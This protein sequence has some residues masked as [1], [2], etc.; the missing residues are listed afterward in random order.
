MWI[1]TS[2]YPR[3]SNDAFNAVERALGQQIPPAYKEFLRLENGGR[4]TPN[5]DAS[6][7]VGVVEFFGTSDQQKANLLE[8]ALFWSGRLSKEYLPIAD[9][10]GG[11]LLLLRI[12][13]DTA[14]GA[15]IAWDHEL[16]GQAEAFMKREKDF[17]AF[18]LGVSPQKRLP[19]ANL[20]RQEKSLGPSG[21][22]RR[23]RELVEE[24]RSGKI[25]VTD[26]VICCERYI[27]IVRRGNNNRAD[28]LTQLLVAI[29]LDNGASETLDTFRTTLTDN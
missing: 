4:A 28:R 23:M 27:P 15:V 26:F 12:G 10:E 1:L 13:S 21:A 11:N 18:L 19:S 3:A 2:P 20:E 14:K 24:L 16:E 29:T 8:K 5:V 9:C 6:G 22:R 7:T 25:D 17:T